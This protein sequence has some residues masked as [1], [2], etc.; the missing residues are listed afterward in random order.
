MIRHNVAHKRRLM[1]LAPVPVPAQPADQVQPRVNLHHPLH[2]PRERDPAVLRPQLLHTLAQAPLADL[3]QVRHQRA[4][5][6]EEAAPAKG[7]SSGG[8]DKKSVRKLTYN[9][10]RELEGM[11][12][13]IAK[14][15]AEV[16][17]LT[18]ESVDPKIASKATQLNEVISALSKAQSEVE[19]LYA[20]W[21]E[22]GG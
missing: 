8:G 9:D 18:A 11:E 10:Q 14:A 17:R 22:L 20:R 21:T 16:E 2:R 4:R 19:R 6:A 7:V 12:K 13:A 5:R 15:E 1:Q 3:H